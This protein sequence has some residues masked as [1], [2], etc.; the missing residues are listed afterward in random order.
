MGR[1]PLKAALQVIERDQLDHVDIDQDLSG[2]L[3]IHRDPVADDGLDLSYPPIV[4]GWMANPCPGHQAAYSRHRAVTSRVKIRVNT[5]VEII[6][7]I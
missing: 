2:I 4:L 3:E 5:L 7:L 6:S 1:K